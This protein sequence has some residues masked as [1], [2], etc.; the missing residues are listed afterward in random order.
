MSLLGTR[1][2]ASV[3]IGVVWTV[4]LNEILKDA[5]AFADPMITLQVLEWGGGRDV[6]VSCAR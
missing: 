6:D 2:A 1:T 3:G 5:H 4:P